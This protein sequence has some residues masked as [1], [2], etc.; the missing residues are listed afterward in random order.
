MFMLESNNYPPSTSLQTKSFC[1]MGFISG[2][3]PKFPNLNHFFHSTSISSALTRVRW[4]K[5][6]SLT[7]EV[8]EAELL[9]VH[10][11]RR[12]QQTH[13]VS[14]ARNRLSLV[15]LH[16]QPGPPPV[17][18]P[19]SQ[20]R[21][22]RARPPDVAGSAGRTPVPALAPPCWRCP[23]SHRWCRLQ[24]K[25]EQSHYLAHI[26]GVTSSDSLITCLTYVMSRQVTASLPG[27]HRWCHLQVK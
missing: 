18:Q 10:G 26:G 6:G 15:W 2:T 4:D 9:C 25:S 7:Y 3:E 14:D 17:K 12:A 20:L 8:G 11:V 1:G 13:V 22:G 21:V 27:S 19:A 5:V 16:L 24:A 23:R